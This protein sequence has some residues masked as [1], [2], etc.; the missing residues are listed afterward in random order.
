MKKIEYVKYGLPQ[1]VYEIQ[2]DI[3]LALGLEEDEIKTIYELAIGGECGSIDKLTYNEV[4]E[5]KKYVSKIMNDIIE[6]NYYELYKK[7]IKELSFRDGK[8]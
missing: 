5:I 3:E 2:T 7:F 6:D 4:V 8:I 1:R